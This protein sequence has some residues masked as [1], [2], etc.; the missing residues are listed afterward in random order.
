MLWLL[1][2]ASHF[3]MIGFPVDTRDMDAFAANLIKYAETC[4]AVPLQDAHRICV[5]SD[6]SGAELWGGAEFEGW[7]GCRG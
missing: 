2:A 7:R 6:K 3:P 4:E 5:I 1:A